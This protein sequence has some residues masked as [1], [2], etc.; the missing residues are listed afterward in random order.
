MVGCWRGY[1]SR[2]RCRF[3]YGPADAIAPHCLLLQV[4][5]IGFCFTFLVSAQPGSTGQ[6]PESCKMV[7]VVEI[8]CIIEYKDET[9]P[10]MLYVTFVCVI[11]A[12]CS[13]F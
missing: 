10:V 2:A 5:Q 7:L 3:A 12:S 13:L 8:T 6:N 4:I 1:L 9:T 11:Y